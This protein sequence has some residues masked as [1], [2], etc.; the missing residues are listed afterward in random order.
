MLIRNEYEG[1]RSQLHLCHRTKW[2]KIT[3]K[4]PQ[5]LGKSLITGKMKI[6]ASDD[7]MYFCSEGLSSLLGIIMTDATQ[8]II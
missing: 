5:Y 3:E 4:V 2:K 1:E 8:Y 6:S 7:Y